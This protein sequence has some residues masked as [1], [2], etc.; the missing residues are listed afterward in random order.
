MA[1][2]GNRG[3]RLSLQL[4]LTIQ[5]GA[6]WVSPLIHL[7]CCVLLYSTPPHGCCCSPPMLLA[8]CVEDTGVPPLPL[9]FWR[10]QL[11]FCFKLSRAPAVTFPG[12]VYTPRP[13]PN[14]ADGVWPLNSSCPPLYR[15]CGFGP[16]VSTGATC[17][18]SNESCPLTRLRVLTQQHFQQVPTS[19]YRQSVHPG[20]N[21]ARPGRGTNGC[22]LRLGA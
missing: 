13:S 15:S 22:D 10:G 14:F 8:G 20:A 2:R 19:P 4:H 1:R 16:T 6:M 12:G 11:N 9:R 17:A 3:V 7:L 5:R 18:P 21:Q